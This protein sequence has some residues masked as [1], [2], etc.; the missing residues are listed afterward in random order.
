M[1]L[2]T[3]LEK[4][5][6]SGKTLIPV[7]VHGGS[8]FSRTISTI[9]ELQPGAT[10]MSDG[11]SISRNRVADAEDDVVAWVNGLNLTAE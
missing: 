8:G 5:D 3:F 10:V 4:Y 11:L 6:F 9:A 2:Y 1:P 7:T